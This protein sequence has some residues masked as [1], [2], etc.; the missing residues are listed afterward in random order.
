[1]GQ[2]QHICCKKPKPSP[3]LKKKKPKKKIIINTCIKKLH[4]NFS[5]LQCS[6]VVVTL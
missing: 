2:P 3:E 4:S 5:I 1:M 6:Y